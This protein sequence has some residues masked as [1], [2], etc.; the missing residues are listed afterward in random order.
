MWATHVWNM[1]DF[2]ADARSEGGC[3]G[4]N[5]KGLVTFDRNYRKEAFY[6]HKAWLSTDPFVHICGKH[7]INHAEPI[8][9][10]T[11]YSN[12]RSVELLANGRSLGVQSRE[13]HFFAYE[14]P[15]VGE[16]TLIARAGQCTDE[17]RIVRV[18]EPD[19]GVPDA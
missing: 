2:A 18:T 15:N 8:V 6:A 9:K 16:T 1:F 13:D 19:P 10:V 7:F 17:T 4:M 3:D 12:L 11:V 5:N 14:V